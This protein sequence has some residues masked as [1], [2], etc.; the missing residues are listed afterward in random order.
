LT[1][2]LSKRSSRIFAG[3]ICGTVCE[4]VANEGSP[5]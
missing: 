2:R 4:S 1:M 5:A 3:T